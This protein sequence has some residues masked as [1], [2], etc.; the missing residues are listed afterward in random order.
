MLRAEPALYE[1]QFNQ[2]GFEWVDLEHRGESVVV[3]RRKGKDPGDDL[4]IILNFTPV[5]RR[6]WKVYASG[7][8]AWKEVFN[9]DGTSILG[10][11]GYE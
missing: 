10:H 5:V 3:Y 6:D 1:N 7:K 8:A 2:H 9:S 11:R 4:L